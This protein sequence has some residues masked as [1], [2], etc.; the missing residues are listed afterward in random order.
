[1]LSDTTELLILKK[2]GGLRNGYERGKGTIYHGVLKE[3]DALKG[4]V[5]F[6][7]HAALCGQMP[8]LQW[9]SDEGS[10]V[11]CPRCLRRI[12]ERTTKAPL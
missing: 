2:A 8:R 5:I 3:A 1:M 10:E 9:S 12:A 7:G 6:N 4:W 11:T